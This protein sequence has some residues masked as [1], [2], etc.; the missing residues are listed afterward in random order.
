MDL[1]QEQAETASEFGV[2][3]RRYRIAAGLTQGEVAE[4]AG[5]SLR[6]VGDIE[7]G[8]RRAPY[9][10]TVIRLA[11]ALNLTPSERVILEQAQRRA[12]RARTDAIG[13]RH[14][15]DS[16]HVD[17]GR[18]ADT[19]DAKTFRAQALSAQPTPFIGREDEVETMRARIVDPAT[20]LLTLVGPGGVGKTR[21]AIQVAERARDAF[22]DGVA[23]I[24]LSTIDDP[25]LVL[26]TIARVLGIGETAGETIVDTVVSALRG[27]RMLLV[28]DNFEQILAAAEEV[29]ALLLALPETT[30][31]VTSRE[32][33]HVR[34]E[35]LHVVH[36]LQVPVA[37][38]PPL[39]ALSRYEAV[40]LFIARAQDVT[41]DFM[42]TA[43][44]AS[45][46]VEI[47]ARLDGLPL[48]IELAAA[49][50]RSLSAATLRARLSSRLTMVAGGARD[51]PARQQ[52]LR[53]T[54]TWSHDL[55]DAGERALFARLGVFQGGCT[56][57]AVEA[58]CAT[59][60]DP[61]LD[62]LDG[63]EALLDK[64]LLRREDGPGGEARFAML[65]TIHEY[66]RERLAH[67]GEEATLRRVH[68]DYVLA[69]VKRAEPELTRAGQATWLARLD[70]DY[71][72]V[73]TALAWAWEHADDGDEMGL[74]L[75]GALWRF[76][77]IRGHLAEG[78]RWLEGLL[79]RGG[80][81]AAVRAQALNGAGNLAWSQGDYAK[82]TAWYEESIVL[83][84]QVD[85]VVGIARA[86]SN[87]GMVQHEQGDLG[88]AQARYEE[89][90]VIKR[91]QR[92]LDRWGIAATLNNLG[93]VVHEQ[94]D[95]ARARTLLTESLTL[96]R[97]IG[98]S[99]GIA[100]TLGNLAEVA[101]AEGDYVH[102]ATLYRDSVALYQELGDHGGI[103]S[104]CEGI[105]HLDAQTE[106]PAADP[107]R[108]VRLLAAANALR[109][110]ADVTLPPAEYDHYY[111]RNLTNLR[112]ALGDSLFEDAWAV[113][114]ALS[115]E[116][117][118]AEV[119]ARDA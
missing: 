102:A 33:L 7:R 114:Q 92:D 26:P 42:M 37:P 56:L 82:A 20:H 85:D 69:L 45:T 79:G 59:T 22:A 46:I 107:S 52:T 57:A 9:P 61:P 47:C 62:A 116:R 87:L 28:L 29:Q 111:G 104:G 105:A 25:G 1:G 27:K 101:D 96:K 112:Q 55:L 119:L 75:A 110:D 98:D 41:P 31:L 35:R 4:Q 73:R 78:R 115:V 91:Q 65:E 74:Q 18:C 36:P 88:G 12:R 83:W 43:D 99:A 66:A 19:S 90:L 77:W 60:G 14:G 49:R 93:R 2:V 13:G 64:N 86:L 16:A 15:A 51:L 70:A 23:L 95:R 76:W 48:A 84:R 108:A 6:G 32:A 40:A 72:N 67:R 53:A 38:L 109:I 17:D 89:S 113:G 81:S 117:I 54:I 94:G 80:G 10:D 21:L 8:V 44:T 3:L 50:V 24:P 34:G 97:E 100:A 11:R 71:D 58:V 63:V 118:V 30:G 103:A 5:L 106:N 39:D 68:A